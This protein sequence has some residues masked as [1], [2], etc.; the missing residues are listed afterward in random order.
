MKRPPPLGGLLP[1]TSIKRHCRPPKI[2]FSKTNS[3]HGFDKIMRERRKKKAQNALNRDL[4]Y[5][6]HMLI[7]SISE[8]L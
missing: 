2:G 8:M 5:N 1:D 7:P 3:E 6:L 4:P